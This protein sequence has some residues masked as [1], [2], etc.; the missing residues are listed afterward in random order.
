MTTITISNTEDAVAAIA[1]LATKSIASHGLPGHSLEEAGERMTSD[2][3]LDRIRTAYNRH[4]GN[5]MTPKDAV[6]AVGQTVTAAYY[7]SAG[8][9]AQG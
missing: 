3:V 8:I 4:T 2:D 1:A 7:N 9:P 6:I 5:G